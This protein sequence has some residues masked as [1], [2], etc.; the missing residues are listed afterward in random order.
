MF[1]NR[2][3][4]SWKDKESSPRSSDDSS[5]D[6]EMKLNPL[7]N[8]PVSHNH[9]SMMQLMSFSWESVKMLLSSNCCECTKCGLLVKLENWRRWWQNG[10]LGAN[11][12]KT[13]N[14][15]IVQICWIVGRR[16]KAYVVYFV[17][18]FLENSE[19]TYF[20]PKRLGVFNTIFPCILFNFYMSQSHSVRFFDWIK[21]TLLIV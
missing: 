6:P 16:G 11:S 3:V 20:S 1:S 18:V 12:I 2:C 8:K 4:R 15:D 5:N 9:V 17:I 7:A 10:K 19:I 21:H 14:W 13:P